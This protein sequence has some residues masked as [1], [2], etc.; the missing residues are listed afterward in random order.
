MLVLLLPDCVTL[1]KSC[2]LSCLSCLICTVE[3]TIPDL[4]AGQ[5]GLTEVKVRKVPFKKCHLVRKRQCPA[6]HLGRT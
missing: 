6:T 3:M 2:G 1:G 5:E 4:E